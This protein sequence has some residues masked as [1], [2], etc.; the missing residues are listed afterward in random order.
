MRRN[1]QIYQAPDCPDTPAASDADGR[2]ENSH[3]KRNTNND[4][5]QPLTGQHQNSTSDRN[6]Q[7]ESNS[8]EAD[9]SSDSETTDDSS[10]LTRCLCCW[11]RRTG[12]N[13]VV[14]ETAS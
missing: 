4:P 12:T 8:R 1:R 10:I 2:E 13:R 9:S 6:H 3:T 5:T 7:L 14:G 11:R